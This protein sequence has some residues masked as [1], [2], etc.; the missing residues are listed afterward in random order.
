MKGMCGWGW[1]EG[2]CAGLYGFGSSRRPPGEADLKWAQGFTV[3]PKDMLDL[4]IEKIYF[5]NVGLKK[6]KND[7]QKSMKS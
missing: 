5:K 1:T 6:K 2:A 7:G 4:N 3:Y